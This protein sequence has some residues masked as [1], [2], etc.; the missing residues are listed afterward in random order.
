MIFEP[1]GVHQRSGP[2]SLVL[3][4]VEYKHLIRPNLSAVVTVSDLFDGQIFRR[5]ISTP[6][7]TDT[8]RREQ[9]VRIAYVGFIYAFG[10]PKKSKDGGFEYDQ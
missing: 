1:P 8:Y 7:L 2:F 9:V 10:A 6:T 5:F 4:N 3:V